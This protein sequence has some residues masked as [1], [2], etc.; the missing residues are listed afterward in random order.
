MGYR[1]DFK[2]KSLEGERYRVRSYVV[3]RAMVASAIDRMCRYLCV[4]AVASSAGEL[5]CG[6]V[7]LQGE[8][9]VTCE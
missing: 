5:Q 2:G 8:L 6:Q 4:A 9:E 1:V 7:V 3:E